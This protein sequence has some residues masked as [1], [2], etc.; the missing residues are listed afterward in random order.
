MPGAL[1]REAR[2]EHRVGNGGSRKADAGPGRWEV[3]DTVQMEGTR[4]GSRAPRAPVSQG[5]GSESRQQ[6]P[7]VF[8][9][10]P[11]G[12]ARGRHL[13]THS[14]PPSP[15][16]AGPPLPLHCPHSGPC[17]APSAHS[18]AHVAGPGTRQRILQGLGDSPMTSEW[19]G[20]GET[21]PGGGAVGSPCRPHRRPSQRA[22][23]S[24]FPR[25]EPAPRTPSAVIFQ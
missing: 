21:G 12:N 11:S 5:R 2:S 14:A 18:A 22:V 8:S 9:P 24:G 15:H 7:P 13:K 25:V 23:R 4:A 10:P 17:W 19:V 1:S 16:T 3:G 6:V 20:F